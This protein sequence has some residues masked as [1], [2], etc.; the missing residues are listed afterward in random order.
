MGLA[1]GLLL[2]L[3]TKMLLVNKE[4][5]STEENSSVI[6]QYHDYCQKGDRKEVAQYAWAKR[7]V[8]ILVHIR[9]RYLPLNKC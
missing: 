6:R 5:R 9:A 3:K 4:T 1:W 7:H 8:S 2:A